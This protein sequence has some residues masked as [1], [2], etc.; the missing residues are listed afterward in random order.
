MQL[1]SEQLPSMDEGLKVDLVLKGTAN[2]VLGMVRSEILDG[3]AA[4]GLSKMPCWSTVA[5]LC[6]FVE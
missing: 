1:K 2:P 5:S 4:I 6:V 3:V